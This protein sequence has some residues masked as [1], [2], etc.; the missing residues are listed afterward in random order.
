MIDFSPNYMAPFKELISS[1]EEW[2][3]KRI[4][5]YAFERNYAEGTATIEEAWRNCVFGLS[6]AILE[7]VDT[8][9]PDYEF[10]PDHDFRS[11]PL[12]SFIVDTAK[13][14]RERGVSLQMFHGLMIYYRE[15]WL[16][17]VRNAEFKIDYKNEC[18]KIV[19]RMFDRF[20]IALCTEWA[21]TDRCRQIEELQ[22]RN[23]E[24]TVEKNR[25]LTIFESVPSP[26]FI[27]DDSKQIVNFNFVAAVM[28]NVSALHGSQY[29]PKTEKSTSVV[30]FE[31]ETSAKSSNTIIGKPFITFFP[32]LADDLDV[33]ITGNESSVNLEKEV[34]NEKETKYFNIKLSRRFDVSKTF[35]G[36][37]IILEDITK[38]KQAE[39]E[40]RQAK[41][42][43]REEV[44]RNENRLNSILNILQHSSYSVREFLD[45]TLDEA[46]KLSGSKIGYILHYNDNKQEFIINTWSKGAMKECSIDYKP[47][48][49]YLSQTGIWGE[50]VRQR[51]AVILNEF[52]D[53]NPL[54]RGYPDGHAHIERFMEIPVFSDNHI[55]AVVAVANKESEYDQTD[56]LQLS[57]LMDSVWKSVDMKL[58]QEV[59]L[60]SEE[61]YRTVFQT[62]GSATIIIEEDT[63]ISLVNDEY[64]KLFGYSREEIEGQKS[65]IEFVAKNDIEKIIK[66][67]RLR[68]IEPDTIPPN[69]EFQ[70]IDR[71]GRIMDLLISAAM[72]P[73]AGKSVASMID[74]SDRKRTERELYDANENL[75]GINKQLQNANVALEERTTELAVA[76][77]KAEAANKAKSAFLAN[78]SHELRTPLNAILGYA[79][80]MQR[81]NNLSP[82]QREYLNTINSSG[83]HLLALINEVLEISKIEARRITLERV[84]FDLHTLFYDLEKMFRFR[85]NVKDL[86]LEFTGINT[87]PRYIIADENKLRQILIN[88]LGNA[89]KFSE[90]GAINVRIT[91]TYGTLDEMRLVVE[92]QDTGMGIAENEYDK[93]FQYFEQTTS[94]R[95]TQG[96]TGLGLAISREYARMMDGDITFISQVGKGS[97]FR[98]EIGVRQGRETELE[99][100]KRKHRVIGLEKGKDSIPRILVVEDMLESRNLLSKLL[101]ITGFEVRQAANGLEAMEIFEQWR[102]HFIWMDIRMPV[103]NGLEATR[104]IKATENGKLTT[105]V[106][107]SANVLEEEKQ[108]I[109]AV[110][111]DGVVWKPYR[112]EEIFESMAE[113]M[114]LKYIYEREAAE[115]LPSESLVEMNCEQLVVALDTDLR[116]ELCE[117]VLRLNIEQIMKVIDRIM[118]QDA[119]IGVALKK[120]VET[121]DFESLLN[122]LETELKK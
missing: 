61:K 79:Q 112:E 38:E 10:G 1:Q 26:V 114:G 93:L 23:R 115:E 47:T 90:E 78:M 69:Y 68:R 49:F 42:A 95:Q 99:E 53:P 41:D 107:L 57:L 35:V 110:G 21:E 101:E 109:L 84:S 25:F 103:M 2:L 52:Q 16:D 106:A 82:G 54:K 86:Q 33:F 40:L 5:H 118:V 29:Y 76:K 55:V 65:F 74:I 7:S 102:P 18:L 88:L 6:R 11:D 62:T 60:D 51:K 36:G 117:A 83:E 105:V 31:E 59:L 94:G 8:I 58:M 77:D 96:G 3:M 46:I 85:T 91:G 75:I 56:V 34:V 72:I 4:F 45:Y 113:H 111:C 20:I 71:Q 28:L 37:V 119:S 44:K 24:T 73:G 97:T 15:A 39:E 92:I 100:G 32:W 63:T 108:A 14:H 43:Q 121:L 120:V 89:V 13:R 80:I 19:A 66:Y 122:L 104:R 98:V 116:Q 12:C 9:Y 17:L 22:V 64:C 27:I 48:V 67:H 87:I 70:A 50:A 81:D 30:Q